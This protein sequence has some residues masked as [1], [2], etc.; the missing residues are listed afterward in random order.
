MHS[1]VLMPLIWNDEITMTTWG[2]DVGFLSE[3]AQ[4]A[5]MNFMTLMNHQEKKDQCV[6]RSSSFPPLFLLLFFKM[7]IST[8]SFILLYCIWTAHCLNCGDL[9]STVLRFLCVGLT[10]TVC[11]AFTVYSALPS[12]T[13]VLT[14][15]VWLKALLKGT[16]SAMV[17]GGESTTN[18]VF[19]H[20]FSGEVGCPL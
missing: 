7:L 19:S 5:E 6:R 4:S 1:L 8:H 10:R 3:A 11:W 18:W 2:S 17:K 20:R 9:A 15:S 14:H 16:L 13:L 12:F